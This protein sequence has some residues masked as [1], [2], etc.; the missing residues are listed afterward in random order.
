M[1]RLEQ[2]AQASALASIAVDSVH[3]QENAQTEALQAP[4]YLS[5]AL[6]HK[7]VEVGKGCQELLAPCITALCALIHVP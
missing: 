6:V 7:A 4:L 1:G 3:V 5:S 2:P